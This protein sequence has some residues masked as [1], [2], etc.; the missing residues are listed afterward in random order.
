M[1][2]LA[3]ITDAGTSIWLDDLSQA[4]FIDPSA[5][6]S[7]D[8]LITESEVRGV[9]TN[10]SIFAAALSNSNLYSA[11]FER[12]KRSGA[13]VE[14]AVREVTTNDVRTACD[15]LTGVYESSNGRDGRVS[16]EVDP[17]SAHKTAE[18]I[19]EARELWKIVDRKNL[20]IKVPATLEGLPAIRTLI[21]EGIS[22]N[23]TLI[24]SIERYAAVHDVFTSG[25][26]DRVKAGLP[27]TGIES[28]ASLFVSRVDSE[29]DRQIDAIGSADAKTLRGRAA[30]AN[31]RLVYERFEVLTS[32][33][34]W[35]ALADLG[36][37]KQ[38]P[39]WASTGVKDKSYGDTR[40][41]VELVAPE[42]VN[43]MPEAT[44]LAVKDHG[45]VR[46]NAIAGTYETAR[47][48]LD[49]LSKIGI[50]YDQVVS[51]LE[52]EGVTKFEDAWV[53]LLS[54]VTKLMKAD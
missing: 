35:K 3:A 12:L 7:L 42:T 54:S 30:I 24:F 29:V 5:E 48:D 2:R 37:T 9:T 41:V 11:A 51:H 47:A 25:L 16:I 40:Y 15:L 23:V 18:S 20:F 44:L 50:S 31:A 39:L 43:T 27:V 6:H 45:V 26:E 1:N 49:A 13:T 4:R 21:S 33:S 10:P 52:T 38:R 36:A 28:V 32:S 17:R 34:R 14:Q 53:G 22:V 8:R 46:G 19:A